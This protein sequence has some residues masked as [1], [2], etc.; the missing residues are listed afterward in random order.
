MA[1]RLWHDL[2]LFADDKP[3]AAHRCHRAKIHHRTFTRRLGDWVN[4]EHVLPA[5]EDTWYYLWKERRLPA[6]VDP[7]ASK[8]KN[9]EDRRRL[10]KVFEQG[11][12]KTVG[13][14]L[15]LFPMG[16]PGSG[17]WQSGQWHF[18]PDRMYLIPGD[19]PMGLRLP[20]DSLPWV[21]P[22]DFPFMYERDPMDVLPALPDPKSRQMRLTRGRAFADRELPPDAVEL[23]R[24]K[25]KVED[26]VI[27]TALCAESRDG[28]LHIFMPPT[29]FVEDYL[30]LVAHLEE[31]AAE[32]KTPIII[33]GYTPPH[34][35]RSAMIKV[36]PDPGVIEVNV[37]PVKNWDEAV[38]V[39]LGPL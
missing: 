26:P 29:R 37:H 6:N 17:R 13:Y 18:R 11:L 10:A 34:D 31:T 5:F 4:P 3:A 9:E 1:F 12:D 25:S 16:N 24:R 36:T 20:L 19:S 14:V 27:R 7:F 33:E 28:I 30:D 8:L 32:L 21:K 35:P 38:Q 22:N 23:A 2:S 39:T 15:P